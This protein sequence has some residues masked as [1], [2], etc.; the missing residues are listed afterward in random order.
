VPNNCR[1]FL[2]KQLALE[3]LLHASQCIRPRC[4]HRLCR[5]MKLLFRH[6]IR[7]Q[8]RQ[9]GGCLICKKV[10]Y[11]MQLHCCSCKD[12]DCKIARCKY[13]INFLSF[14]MSNPCATN[15]A[16]PHFYISTSKFKPKCL[17]YGCL[18]QIR[19]IKMMHA[20]KIFLNNFSSFS[21]LLQFIG[22]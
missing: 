10:W 11:L 4:E 15:L 3:T 9:S 12:L 17:S 14:F 5:K 18:F 7:C 21:S 20:R 2:W 6:C 22:D 16:V 19:R 13:V 8:V 1:L